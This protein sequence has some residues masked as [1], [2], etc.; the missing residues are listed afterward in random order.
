MFFIVKE[1]RFNGKI[2]SFL[3]F[4]RHHKNMDHQKKKEGKMK[5]IVLFLKD[6]SGASA[7]EYGLLIAL[8]AAVVAATV[9]SI[10]TRLNT[11]FTKLLDV[12]PS[13]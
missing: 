9:T 11:A 2:K 1:K 8:I 13:S 10:G 12:L 7:A 3:I 4:L 5:N 6:E